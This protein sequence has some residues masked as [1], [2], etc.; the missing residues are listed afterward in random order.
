MSAARDRL[1]ADG[2]RSL[3]GQLGRT[4]VPRERPQ[5]LMAAAL[6]AGGG[7]AGPSLFRKTDIVAALL[8]VGTVYRRGGGGWT[9]LDGPSDG[10]P[11]TTGLCIAATAADPPDIPDPSSTVLV[12]GEVSRSGTAGVPLYCGASGAITETN[13][14]DIEDETEDAPW[15]WQIGWQIDGGT[16][17]ILP[18]DPYRPRLVNLCLGDGTTSLAATLREYPAVP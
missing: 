12:C 4:D 10:T 6:G 9:V 2:L 3:R 15:V 16:A 13:P 11:G 1:N 18:C 5:P 7:V 8:V 17:I 14:A